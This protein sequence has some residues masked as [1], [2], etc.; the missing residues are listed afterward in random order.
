MANLAL[1]I[2]KEAFLD[3]LSLSRC[4]SIADGQAAGSLGRAAHLLAKLKTNKI[5]FSCDKALSIWWK[6]LKVKS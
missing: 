1:V 4:G 2:L 6:L 3:K 5:Y